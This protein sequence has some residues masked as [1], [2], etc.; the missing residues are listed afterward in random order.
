MCQCEVQCIG[1]ARNDYIDA[2]PCIFLPKIVRNELLRL[3]VG[4]PCEIE[5]LVVDFDWSRCV[6]LKGAA[7]AAIHPRIAWSSIAFRIEHDDSFDGRGIVRTSNRAKETGR[8][9]E[10]K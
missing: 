3:L 6:A 7:N 4:E 10:K 9:S 1:E 2:S 8:S 5:I